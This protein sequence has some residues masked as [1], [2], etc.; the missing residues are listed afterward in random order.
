MCLLA[1]L[2]GHFKTCAGIVNLY[3]AFY[4]PLMKTSHTIEELSQRARNVF[5][6]IVE[7]YMHDGSPVP[8][9]A[10]YQ[11]YGVSSATIRNIM[12]ELMGL[13]LIHSPHISAGRIPTE[14]GMRFFVDGLL[15]VG[16]LTDVERAALEADCTTNNTSFDNVFEKA[17]SALSKFSS[18]AGLVTAP[19][20]VNSNLSHV[21]FIP[22]E[23]NKA[24]VVLVSEDNSVENRL[25]DL[26]PGTTPD[27]LRQAGDFLS[28]RLHGR[29]IYQMRETILTE[30]RQNQSDMDALLTQVVESGLATQLDDGKLIVHGRSRLITDNDANADLARL[31]D[32]MNQLEEKDT[33]A[34]LLEEAFE[35]DGVKI[36]IG[37]ENTI[38]K[39][40]GQSLILS[41][42]RNATDNIV[43]AIG[44]IG[45]TNLNYGRIIPSV[46]YMAEYLSRHIRSAQP[47]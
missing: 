10:L 3:K 32:L 41:P 23:S 44:V 42:Y 25:I 21:Q 17:S 40:S 20:Q 22:L 47:K 37:A 28:Q 11:K 18:S 35:A 36:Y 24:V 29:T 2:L 13:G 6:D 34:K 30:M 46:N 4:T 26:A 45:P 14:N 16:S 12:Q 15:E 43:G 5:S 8:S 33:T 7:S 27:M 38:F 39:G 1:S 9:K 19:T 31:Q